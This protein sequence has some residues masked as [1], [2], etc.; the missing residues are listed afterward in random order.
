MWEV[1]NFL[2]RISRG[3]VVLLAVV[4]MIL[5][6]IFILPDQASKAEEASGGAGSP[7]TSL[8]Y[9]PQDL[10]NLAEA[11]GVEG[12]QAYL[13]ARWTFD[14]A[15]PLVYGFF[16]ITTISWLFA[17]GFKPGSHWQLANLAP[18]L[19]VVFDLLEN[20][21]TSI[22]MARFPAQA[23]LA[24]WLA[25]AFTLIKWVFVYGSFGLLVVGL[26]AAIVAG[27]RSRR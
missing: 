5:F 24:A 6:M 16:L 11:Y 27:I 12:R 3:W 4:V 7:D 19:A 25:P 23:S 17:R 8:F 26:V 14:L 10:T 1:S 18:V 15:F 9:S 13:Y 2:R 21:A 20:T 22:V